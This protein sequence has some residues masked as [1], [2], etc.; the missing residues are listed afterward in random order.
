MDCVNLNQEN[1]CKTT[2]DEWNFYTL[3]ILMYVI[4]ILKSNTL[5]L[6]IPNMI[7]TADL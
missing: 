5:E 7:L 3:C 6:K 2:W 4:Y 1:A